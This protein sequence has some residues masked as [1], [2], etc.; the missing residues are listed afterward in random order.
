M[1]SGAPGRSGI[2]S[3]TTI[4]SK[5]AS[6]R[7]SNARPLSTG[8]VAAAYTRRAP[9]SS[10]VCAAAFSVPAVSIMSSSRTAVRSLHVADDVAD[11]GDLVGGALLREDR[12]V[13]ADLLGELLVE[14]RAADVRRDDHEVGQ[15]R[16]RGS[17]G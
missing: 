7:F 14:L 13:A 1:L 8:C 9:D 5:P 11:L 15:V 3:V 10:T 6:A 17:A 2:V 12:Q 16:G 4:S